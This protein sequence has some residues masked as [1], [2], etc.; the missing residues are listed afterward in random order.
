MC[1]SINVKTALF[2]CL[3]AVRMTPAGYMVIVGIR[4]CSSYTTIGDKGIVFQRGDET[5]DRSSREA[6][7]I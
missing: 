1:G 3:D 7:G 2:F 4:C 5:Q 6:T